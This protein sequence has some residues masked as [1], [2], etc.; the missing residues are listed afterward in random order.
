MKAS[1][2][3][4]QRYNI[5]LILTNGEIGEDQI[6][7]LAKKVII[8]EDIDSEEQK[9][10]HEIVEGSNLPLSIIIV[11]IGERSSFEHFKT[12]DAD[13]NP[14][15]SEK[16]KTYQ[17][18]DIV[19]FVQ[20]APRTSSPFLPERTPHNRSG[21]GDTGAPPH[22]PSKGDASRGSRV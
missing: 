21:C 8:G 18:R 7:N 14:L 10:Y 20:P 15:Y 9:T 1:N 22:A 2:S 19:Q 16:T 13:I 5:L 12:L 6:E 3:Q 11:G 4:M 17:A